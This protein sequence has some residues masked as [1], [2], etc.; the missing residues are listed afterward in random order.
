MSIVLLT[1]FVLIAFAANT[2]LCRMALGGDLI[3]PMAY[4]TLRLVSGAL[5][6]IPVSRMVAEP[7]SRKE[8]R[9]SWRSGFALFAYAAAFSLAYVSLE[10]GMG[11]LIL[12]GAVQITMIGSALASGDRLSVAQ[13]AGTFV[14]IG[15]L[16]YLVFPGL[17]APDPMGALLMSIAGIAWGVYSIRGRGAPAPVSMTAGNF[18]RS[19]PFAIVAAAVG[20]STVRVSTQGVLLALISGIVTSGLGYVLWY[21]ALR[22]LTTTQASVVQ[23]LVPVI[24]TFAGVAILAEELSMR[25]VFASAMILGGVALAVVKRSFRLTN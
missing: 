22:H 20:L 11:A 18:L 3:D 19:T 15:G 4:T 7:G 13:W 21:R 12:F 9:G 24:A 23:L 17:S 14:A 25:L 16:A 5:F 6:L 1:T 10:T 8:T 2:L